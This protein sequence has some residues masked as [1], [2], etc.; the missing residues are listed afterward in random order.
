MVSIRVFAIEFLIFISSLVSTDCCM[1][2]VEETSFFL[3]LAKR[4]RTFIFFSSSAATAVNEMHFLLNYSNRSGF[5]S[6]F[7]PKTSYDTPFQRTNPPQIDLDALPEPNLASYESYSAERTL[8][9]SPF[10]A[11]ARHARP[12]AEEAIPEAVGNEL[13]DLT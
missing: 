5:F 2:E 3:S 7:P 10:K 11:A 13:V 1:P 4:M 8:S 12:E 6:I 9:K